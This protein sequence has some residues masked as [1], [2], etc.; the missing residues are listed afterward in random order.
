MR[1]YASNL[2]GKTKRNNKGFQRRGRE[3]K[4][5]NIQVFN[6]ITFLNSFDTKKRE[7]LNDDMYISISFLLWVCSYLNKEKNIQQSKL[8]NSKKLWHF[9]LW[10]MAHHHDSRGRWKRRSYRLVR[11]RCNLSSIL[12]L[13]N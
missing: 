12:V 7:T 11:R 2:L 9:N 8:E 6:S 10:D 5:H 3:S 13:L 1:E 4:E